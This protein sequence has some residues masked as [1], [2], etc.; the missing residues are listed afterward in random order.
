MNLAG[1]LMAVVL[2]CGLANSANAVVM[3]WGFFIDEAQVKNGTEPD[4]STNSPG[5]GTG[6][7]QY[8]TDTNVISY[9]VTWDGL[10]GELTKLHMHGPADSSSSNPQH[11]IEIFGPPNIPASVDL[12]SDTWTD[13]HPLEALQQTGINPATGQPYDPISPAMII[14]IM[15]SGQSYI[16]VHTNVFGV[17]EIRGNLGLPVTT[18]EPG[19]LCLLILG[20]VGVSGR[21]RK[22]GCL[23]SL[24]IISV[25]P[26]T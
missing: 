9:T 16:N 14:A 8:N 22:V 26:K 24:S 20:I 7:F 1:H 5:T 6:H 11:I 12:N 13:S 19:S 2:C 23:E 21:R 25:V 4:G 10:F 3:D 15:Q 18:P 17:G